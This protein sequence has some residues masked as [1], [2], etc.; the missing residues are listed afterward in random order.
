MALL[1]GYFR[2]ANFLAVGLR[3]HV[4]LVGTHVPNLF[5]K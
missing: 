2:N 4:I 3:D 5:L 1:E